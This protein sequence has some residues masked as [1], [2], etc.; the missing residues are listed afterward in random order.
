MHLCF[1]DESG[2]PAKIGKDR[3]RF[4][5]IAGVVLPEERW[6]DVSKKHH[7]LKVRSKYRGEVKWRFFA[8]DN[9]DDANPMRK[10]PQKDRDAFRDSVFRNLRVRKINQSDRRRLRMRSGLQAL[11]RCRSA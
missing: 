4:F 6:H 10:W 8:P 9:D 11:H 1:V 7:G 5:V 3:P 2:T